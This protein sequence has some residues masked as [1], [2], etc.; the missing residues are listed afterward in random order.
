MTSFAAAYQADDF[1]ARMEGEV[2]EAIFR[3]P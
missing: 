1:A 2:V 3:K